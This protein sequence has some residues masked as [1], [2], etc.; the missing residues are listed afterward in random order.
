MEESLL[1]HNLTVHG[2][3]LLLSTYGIDQM[4]HANVYIV[5]QNIGRVVFTGLVGEAVAL[6]GRPTA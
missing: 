5:L 1:R 6:S 3:C 4:S 2:Y